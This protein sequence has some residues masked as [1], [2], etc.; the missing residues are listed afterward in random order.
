VSSLGLR[1]MN[2]GFRLGGRNDRGEKGATEIPPLL[3][4]YLPTGRQAPFGSTRLTTS[5][6]GRIG[7]QA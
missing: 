5:R 1:H 3:R 6:K 2:D 4:R 7:L